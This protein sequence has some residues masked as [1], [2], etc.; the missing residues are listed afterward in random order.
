MLD[1]NAKLSAFRKMVWDEER[2]ISEKEL[3]DSTAINSKFIE[4]K[5][6]N[7]ENDLKNALDSR[8]SFAKIRSNEKI[9]KFEQEQ[10]NNFFSHK[11]YLLND[12]VKAIK[13]KLMTYTQSEEYKNNLDIRIKKSIKDLSL[14]EDEFIV[15]VKEADK[16]FVNFDNVEIMDDKYIG[17]FI[18]KAKDG[19]YQYNQTLLNKIDDNKYEIGKTLYKLFES[20]SFNE[21]E[22]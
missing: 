21:S 18:L 1:L 9:S 6:N 14:S 8:E 2:A 16:D 5:K 22:N 15:L 4:D 20:E 17:G 12:M 7:L 11:Q 19:S 10:K 13:D 3:Y